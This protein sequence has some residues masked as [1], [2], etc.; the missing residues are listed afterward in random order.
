M[1][2]LDSESVES[3]EVT[4]TRLAVSVAGRVVARVLPSKIMVGVSAVVAMAGTPKPKIPEIARET[5]TAMDAGFLVSSCVRMTTPLFYP[6][7]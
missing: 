2:V 3:A 7:F 4:P 6:V 5:I 1:V